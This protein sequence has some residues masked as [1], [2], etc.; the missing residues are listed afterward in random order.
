LEK[1]D[2]HHKKG[3]ETHWGVKSAQNGN[4]KQGQEGR[5]QKKKH[6]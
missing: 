2:T 5:G 1:Y 6:T 4:G 3:T